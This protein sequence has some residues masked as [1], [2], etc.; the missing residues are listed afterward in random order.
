VTYTATFDAART[1]KRILV[2][3]FNYSGTV[4]L[5]TQATNS[6]TSANPSSGNITTTGAYHLALAGYGEYSGNALSS[7]LINGFA[8]DH[9]LVTANKR[10]MW[11]Q[12]TNVTYTGGF[13]V[14][15]SSAAW[16]CNIIA[17]K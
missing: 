1:F 2:K 9:T 17:F 16:V 10:G 8:V 11:D 6:A 12:K 7:P 3:N 15:M 14:T 4:A 5:D 13:A